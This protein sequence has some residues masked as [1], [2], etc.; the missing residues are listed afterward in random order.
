MVITGAVQKQAWVDKTMPPPERVRDNVWSIPVDFGHTPVR[1]TFSYLVFNE[2]GA[3]VV[4][5]PGWD[6]DLGRSQLLAGLELAGSSLDSVA[7]IV[8]TH[9]HPD[10]L[11]M[12]QHL[13]DVT[14]AWVGMHPL[15]A[16][17]LEQ[18]ANPAQA[19][20]LD[21]AWLAEIGV[22]D[23]RVQEVLVSPETIAYM[24]ALARPS[25][26]LE[27][28]DLLP[29]AGTTLR[30]AFTP[31]HTPGHLCIVDEVNELA[32][33]GDHILPR[34]TSNIGLTSTGTRS[35]ALRSYYRSLE[36]MKKWDGFEVLPAHEYRFSGLA[37]RADDLAAHHRDRSNE[38]LSDLEGTDGL[39]VYGIAER[40]SWSRSWSSL[41]GVNLR[42]ALS[43]T[44]AHVDYLIEEGRIIAPAL[45]TDGPRI[46]RLP[47]G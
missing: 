12:V 18:F 6:S 43:E 26:L 19:Q 47:H 22:P 14:G 30:A 2:D 36:T 33:S 7:G 39:S 16:E 42:A 41:D 10:H 9:L 13:A 25:L 38:I 1:Y 17:L 5:D 28:G 37:Q 8:S 45:P 20:L 3:C 34:I 29:L 21:S 44:A 4:I 11:G 31:G 24:N 35:G 15:E 32:F 27:D 23:E 40:I 46:V